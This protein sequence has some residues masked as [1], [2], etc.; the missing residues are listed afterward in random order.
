[1]AGLAM[2]L[3]DDG[4]A[5]VA[6][7]DE[8]AG[9]RSRRRSSARCCWPVRGCRRVRR[10]HVR[11]RATASVAGR[12]SRAAIAGGRVR[13]GIAGRA[14]RA[15]DTRC[16]DVACG[17]LGLAGVAAGRR[18]AV[19]PRLRR[20]CERR[21]L[22]RLRRVAADARLHASGC[23]SPSRS[24]SRS[25]ARRRWR[26][27]APILPAALLG[28]HHRGRH[29][30]GRAAAAAALRPA[31][32][33]GVRGDRR[34]ARRRREG[35]RSRRRG[36]RLPSTRSRRSR[37]PCGSRRFLRRDPTAGDAVTCRSTDASDHHAST[38][39]LSDATTS[40]Q[41]RSIA[42]VGSA[43]NGWQRIEATSTAA[44]AARAR[45]PASRA[46]AIRRSCPS[47]QRAGDIAA[48]IREH[49]VV[50]VSGETGSGKTTQLPKICL[51]AG[52]GERG[53]IGHT[54]PRRIAA[55]AVAARIAQEL[56][57]R[58]ARRSATRS[59]SPTARGPTRTSS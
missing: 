21:A 16:A 19:G 18:P 46:I 17:T 33:A 30:V 22:R 40:P 44:R 34:A 48:A 41:A 2:R 10:A 20:P 3:V 32:R 1:M 49:P 4:A 25:N 52:R 54:Q 31:A 8:G 59:A 47:S 57:T 13:R 5:R 45:A 56:G 51:A 38:R 14:D 43:S 6:V 11:R 29:R 37:S 42:R 35:R 7:D 9:R 12:P 26:R 39:R 27:A 23:G 50:I 58:S 55:R 15:R 53:L 36:C 24:F 28:G